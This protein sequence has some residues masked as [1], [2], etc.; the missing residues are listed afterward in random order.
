MGTNPIHPLGDR[1]SNRL[2]AF[3][4]GIFAVA[5][6]LLV[7]DINFPK[8]KDLTEQGLISALISLWP[9]YFAYLNSFVTVL[10]MWMAHH[11]LFKM[12]KH[13]GNSLIIANGFLMFLA[14]LIPFPTRILG[15]YID[16]GAFRV[17]A[18]FYTGFFVLTSLAF[19]ILWFV[20]LK[21]KKHLHHH[22]SEET[23]K[24]QSKIELTGLICNGMIALISFFFPWLGLI[25][26]TAMWM[27]W[28]ISVK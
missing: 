18:V 22:I 2:E 23:I 17:A 5:I 4:D 16:S 1:D 3:S 24:K 14:V 27:Y 15:D 25:L 13:V 26:T 6:T 8:V 9:K 21:D 12:V 7:L 28:L 19:V 10:L 20:I 11:S